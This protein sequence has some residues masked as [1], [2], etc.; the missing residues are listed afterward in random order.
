MAKNWRLAVCTRWRL[1]A[2]ALLVCL[3]VLCTG[4]IEYFVYTTVDEYPVRRL[5][6]RLLSVKVGMSVAELKS[7]LGP[8]DSTTNKIE[9]ENLILAEGGSDKI[10]EYRYSVDYGLERSWAYFKGIFVDDNEGRVVSINLSRDWHLVLDSGFWGEWLFLV[11]LGLMVLVVLIVV[12]L[13]RRW[14]Q[15]VAD[16]DDDK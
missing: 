15:S 12:L 10:V 2:S 1:L 6:R 4:I 9:R 11:A 7:I 14:C 5:E 13:F 16:A 3:S 8:P